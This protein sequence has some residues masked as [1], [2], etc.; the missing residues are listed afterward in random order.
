LFFR[1]V[2]L[3]YDFEFQK[4]DQIRDNFVCLREV[5]CRTVVFYHTFDSGLEG[6]GLG[7][8]TLELGRLLSGSTRGFLFIDGHATYNQKRKSEIQGKIQGKK[9]VTTKQKDVVFAGK[10]E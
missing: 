3:H 10:D 8:D 6:K 1:G 7:Q 5:P 9:C 4:L 2:V